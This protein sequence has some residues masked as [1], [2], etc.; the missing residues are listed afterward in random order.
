M[1]DGVTSDTI[2]PFVS[3]SGTG[4]TYASID[5]P[6][7]TIYTKDAS[8][9][10][11]NVNK[12]SNTAKNVLNCSTVGNVQSVDVSSTISSTLLNLASQSGYTE[13]V[14]SFLQC[15]SFLGSKN[16]STL[17][18]IVSLLGGSHPA[19]SSVLISAMSAPSTLN[20]QSY[21]SSVLTNPALT[22]ADTADVTKIFDQIGA[23]P[24]ATYATESAG[25][26][27]IPTYDLSLAAQT[28]TPV[29]DSVFGT[30]ITGNSLLT[31]FLSSTPTTTNSN[32]TLSL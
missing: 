32:G 1:I 14:S 9:T 22:S 23:D 19:T 4:A 7:K 8:T 27:T 16:D 28:Q 17:S 24:K 2:A 11:S 3:S 29:L 30:G 25:G 20:Q 18:K 13:L 5:D 31:D 15:Q 26:T 21:T 12:L 10:A 6:T